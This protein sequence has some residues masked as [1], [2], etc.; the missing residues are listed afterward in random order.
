MNWLDLKYQGIL[1]DILLEGKEKGDKTDL[2]F[3]LSFQLD[4][5]LLVTFKTRCYVISNCKIQQKRKREIRGKREEET[6]LSEKFPKFS[7]QNLD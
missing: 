4:M 1:Q 2:K 6:I 3:H 7:N 5:P